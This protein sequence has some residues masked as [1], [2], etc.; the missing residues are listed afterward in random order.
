[1]RTIVLNCNISMKDGV[2][3]NTRYTIYIHIVVYSYFVLCCNIY[4]QECNTEVLAINR[5]DENQQTLA[6]TKYV[7]SSTQTSPDDLSFSVTVNGIKQQTVKIKSSKRF[8]CQ[9][10]YYREEVNCWKIRFAFF[11]E[12]LLDVSNK[13]MPMMTVVI[14]ISI[15]QWW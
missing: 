14:Y 4:I 8:V 2:V 9:V 5:N 7:V 11:L 12:H 15:W 3:K 13:I 10:F 6:T 1:M